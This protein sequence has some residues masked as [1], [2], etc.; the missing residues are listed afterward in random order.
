MKIMDEVTLNVYEV[1]YQDSWDGEV[2]FVKIIAEDDEH[3]IE[4]F[5]DRYPDALIM[6]LVCRGEVF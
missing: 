3:A 5:G 6:N 4:K 1:Q 2:D